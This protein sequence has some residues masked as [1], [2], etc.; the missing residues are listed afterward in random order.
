MKF[1]PRER[2]RSGR[3]VCCKVPTSMCCRSMNTRK[4]TFAC[5]K[6]SW[7]NKKVAHICTQCQRL[8]PGASAETWNSSRQERIKPRHLCDLGTCVFWSQLVAFAFLYLFF[9]CTKSKLGPRNECRELKLERAGAD[10]AHWGFWLRN[11]CVPEPSSSFPISYKAFSDQE[12]AIFAHMDKK[13]TRT[14]YT[15]REAAQSCRERQNSPFCIRDLWP[16]P[17]PSHSFFGCNAPGERWREEIANGQISF[18]LWRKKKIENFLKIGGDSI[19]LYW[20]EP[21][22]FDVWLLNSNSNM[23]AWKKVMLKVMWRA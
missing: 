11:S 6:R 1:L 20:G 3:D 18:V 13:C 17:C 12:F 14:A 10:Q 16:L 22:R 19:S 7:S 4:I 15:I 8:N 23:W 5:L 21:I 2:V 9:V